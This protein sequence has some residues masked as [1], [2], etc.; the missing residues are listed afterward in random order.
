MCLQGITLT[1]ILLN[2]FPK[3]PVPDLLTSLAISSRLLTRSEDGL[4]QRINDLH[5]QWQ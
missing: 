5:D 2:S 1:T 3:V 4:V